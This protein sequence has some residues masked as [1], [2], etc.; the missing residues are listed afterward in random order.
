MKLTR[1]SYN[2]RIYTFGILI[3]AS[4]A[5]VST[6]FATWV[7]SKGANKDINNGAVNVGTITDGSISFGDD[8]TYLNDVDEFLF[9]PAAGDYSGDVALSSAEGTK[10]E[11]LTIVI[12]GT[13]TPAEYFSELGV[14]MKVSDSIKAAAD[15]NYIVLPSICTTEDVLTL[16]ADPLTENTGLEVDGTT[17][18]F[19]YEI[20]FEWGTEF[21]GENPSIY[22]DRAENG[23][24]HEQKKAK[25]V[26]FRRVLLGLEEGTAEEEIMSK[27]SE[28]LL[29]FDIS[30]RASAKV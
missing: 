26:E 14:S 19:S 3:F 28:S 23:L 10:P 4:I 16:D 25:L 24:T 21:G 13:I 2:R 11:N 15:K 29:K 9:N 27:S 6:G 30:L 20:S 18:N 8:I 7:M 17:V 5:S 12:Q 1:K 22:L